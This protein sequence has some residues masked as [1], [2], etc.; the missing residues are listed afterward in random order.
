MGVLI[1]LDILF[2]PRMGPA[3]A[4]VADGI[5]QAIIGSLMLIFLWRVLPRKYPIGFTLRLLLGLTIAAL[6]G[7]IWHPTSRTLLGVSG[8]IFL[9]LRCAAHADQTPE[10]KKTWR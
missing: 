8:G 9:I 4:L 3:G 6:P 2:I 5:S 10:R 7:I 1:L